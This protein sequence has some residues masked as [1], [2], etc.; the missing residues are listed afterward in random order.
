MEQFGFWPSSDADVNWWSS[1]SSVHEDVMEFL[2]FLVLK[3]PNVYDAFR[4]IDGP[5]G[6]GVISWD[7]FGKGLKKMKF[8]KFGKDKSEKGKKRIKERMKKVWDFLDPSGDGEVSKL[9]WSVM[10]Q[11][12]KEVHMSIGEFVWFLDRT[13]DDLDDAWEFLDEDGSGSLDLE[14]WLSASKSIGYFGPAKPIFSYLD[15]DGEGSVSLD[16]FE[17]LKEYHKAREEVEILDDADR[18]DTAEDNE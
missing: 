9:E 16:E 5:G 17:V 8:K 3:F 4:L 15:N 14:E 6:N 13:F 2:V 11:L 18:P 7:E 12:F 1:I 10:E